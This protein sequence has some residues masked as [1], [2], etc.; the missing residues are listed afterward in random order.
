VLHETRSYAGLIDLGH[1]LRAGWV[2]FSFQPKIDLHTRRLVGVEMLARAQHPFH[3][4]LS[5]GTFLAGADDKCLAQLAHFSIRVA[6]EASATLAREGARVPVTVNVP[7]EALHALP[8]DLIMDANAQG[9]D[10]A[11]IVFDVNEDDILGDTDALSRIVDELGA[12]GMKL[13]ADGFGR[14]L[15]SLIESTDPIKLKERMEEMSRR[16]IEL[17]NVSVFELK[18]DRNLSANC[19]HDE[20]RAALTRLVIDL[21]HHIGS[22][23]VAV[24]IESA[25]D[26]KTLRE[27]GCDAGQGFFFGHPTPLHQLVSDLRARARK[28]KSTARWTV[29]GFSP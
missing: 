8:T 18:L 7:I 20:N 6:L 12:C 22:R 11:G 28:Q 1:A 17:K 27:M 5:A 16:L 26:C 4:T 29:A 3:G 15:S 2:D 9:S 13:A 19:A 25:L 14:S 24:G 21:I 10:W 23:A